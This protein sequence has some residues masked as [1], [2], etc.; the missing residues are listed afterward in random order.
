MNQTFWLG[1]E[2]TMFIA[3][4]IILYFQLFVSDS[5]Q[6]LALFGIFGG[7]GWFALIMVG[8]EQI[9]KESEEYD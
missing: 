5:P 4:L 8:L 3:A 7:L 6:H 2:I 9:N 1:F